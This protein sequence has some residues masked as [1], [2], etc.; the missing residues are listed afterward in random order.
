M[1]HVIDVQI[2]GANDC[3]IVRYIGEGDRDDRYVIKCGD[4]FGK[5]ISRQKGQRLVHGVCC[6]RRANQDLSEYK[7][8]QLVE[9]FVRSAYRNS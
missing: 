2:F 3:H 9:R 1:T 7:V 8:D 5:K 6:I 4:E